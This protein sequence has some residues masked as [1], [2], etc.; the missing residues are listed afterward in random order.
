MVEPAVIRRSR[1]VAL[2]IVGLVFVSVL[3]ACG[4]DRSPSALDPQGDEAKRIAGVWWL[5]FGLAIVVYAVVAGFV[6]V[7]SLRGRRK[8]SEEPRDKPLRDSAFIWIGGILA[9]VLILALLAVV[10]VHTG[11]A[12]RNPKAGELRVDVTGERWWWRIRYHDP[13]FETANELHLPVGRPVAIGLHSDNVIHSFWVPQLAAKVDTIPGQTNVLR[14]TPEKIGV[15]R[16][17]CAEYCGVQHARMQFLVI[18]DSAEDFGRWEARRENAPAEPTS[19][20]AARGR[21]V[22]EKEACAGCHTIDGTSAQ[23]HVGPNLTDI[24]TRSTIAGATLD[25]TTRNL[26][27][28][29]ENPRKW[30]PGVIMPPAVISH[31]D[32]RAIVA[33]LESL[34]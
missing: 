8:G 3:S 33:Y 25:N 10:T 31:D 13:S 1:S 24:G 20:E 22:F 27:E 15:Y 5:M 7:S 19:E 30:K 12:L 9:P 34:K 18:V 6:I 23:G 14:F 26:T 32:V 28:W 17:L 4:N 2:V 21:M 16:G 29:I 11:A